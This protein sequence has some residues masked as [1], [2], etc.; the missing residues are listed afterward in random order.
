MN[1]PTPKIAP[2]RTIRALSLCA[3]AVALTP[4]AFG[5]TEV[6][7]G[8]HDV[9]ATTNWSDNAN[10]FN[11]QG[12]GGPG[13]NGNDVIF[14][15]QGSGTQ[16]TINSVVDANLLKPF[17]LTFTNNS[18]NGNFQTVLIPD[19]IVVTNANGLTT[20]IRLSTANSYQT[21]AA[22]VG[23]GTLVQNGSVQVDNTTT[24]GSSG[25]LPWLDLSG[26]TNFFM[27]NN[28]GATLTVAGTSSGSE[29]R[30]SGRLDLAQTNVITVN[31]INI[32]LGTG[33]GGIG[34]TLNLGAGSNV[35]N[36]L[37]F[38][39]AGGKINTAAIKFLGATGGLRIRG[40]NG[41]DSDRNVTLNFGARTSSG[42]GQAKG[43]LDATGGHPVD[44]KAA[45]A[46]LGRSTST[47]Q[48]IGNIGFDT[49]TVDITT[50]NMGVTTSTGGATGSITNGGGFLIVSNMSM[51]NQTGTTIAGTG[52]LYINGTGVVIVSNNIV[53]T[54]TAGVGNIIMTGGSLSV[55]VN[56]GAE[57]NAIDNLTVADSTL[58][59][60]AKLTA[61]AYFTNLTAA[62][63]S[64][65]INVTSV[66]G[67]FAYP[68]QF[69][70]IS[71]VNALGDNS[72][73]F[74]GALPSSFQGY[75]SNNVTAFS[76]D[77]VIT[78]GP[79]LAQLKSIRWSGSPNG[80][81][82]NDV[83]TLNWLTNSISVNYNQGDTVTFDDTLTGT[84]NVN[85]TM[86][87]TP[88]AVTV[89][90]S[91][92]NY[93][94]TGIGTI[95]GPTGLTK[96][97]TGK[98]ILDNSGTND[99]VGA[100]TINAGTLQVGNND[101]NGNL[102]TIGAWDNEG[103]LVFS[104]SNNLVLSQIIPGAG[105]LVQNGNG[106]LTLSVA[107]TYSGSTLVAKGTLALSSSGSIPNTSGILA[108]GGA[109]DV[110]QADPGVFLNVVGA[111]GGTLGIGTN[112]VTIGALGLTNSVITVSPNF[113]NPQT[114][115]A[116]TLAIGGTTNIINVTAVLNVPDGQALPIVIPII[117]YA[118]TPFTGAFNIG[119]TNFP[120]AFVSNDV[121]NSTIDL[122]LTA[123]P[124]LVTWNGGSTTGNNFSD[125]NNWSGVPI[126]LG[127]ALTFDGTTRLTPLNDTPANT[128]YSNITF[129][130]SAGAFTLTG[131][132]LVYTGT[133]INNS[134][135]PQTIL[136][137]LGFT[138]NATINGAV[139][140]VILGGGVTN[141]SGATGSRT[142]TLMGTGILTNLFGSSTVV[143][144]TNGLILNDSAA[145]WT[146]LDN[147]T[148]TRSV[149]PWAFELNSGTFNFG[150]ASSA[151]W[152][153]STSGQGVP[154][155]NQLGNGAIAVLNIS[156][157]VFTTSARLNTGVGNGGSGTINQYGGLINIASQFQG[158]NGSA[159][160]VSAVNLFGGTMNI[161]VSPNA[162]NTSLLTTNLG[163]F[164][165]AS[166]G[167][168]SLTITNSALLNCGI[169]DVS[170]SI[171]GGISGVVNLDGGTIV[172]NSVSTATANQSGTGSTATFN[173]NGGT[174]KARASSAA[175]F[176]GR[177]TA[178]VTPITA[179]VTA[180]GAFIDSDTNTIGFLEPL[181]TD[182][183]LGGAQDG[184]LT[185]LGTGTLRLA[186]TNTYYGDT[187]VNAGTLLAN[188]Q[189]VS[190]TIVASG[191]TLGG[192][193]V[194][195]SNVTVNAGGTLAPG[196]N[197]VGVLTV[198]GNVSLAGATTVEIDK[199]AGTNDLV[200]TTNVTATTITY[201]GTLNV[202]TATGTLAPGDRFQF[203]SATNYLGSF[204]SINSPGVTW[205]TSN[206]N[207]DGSLTVVTV[208]PPGPTTNVTVLSVTLSG[209]NLLVHGT[210]N[211]IPNTSGN[212]VV[213]TST[214]LTTP[215]S[216]WT[217]VQTN[218]YGNTGTV[219]FS[220]PV[221]PGTPQQFIDVKAQ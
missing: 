58:T 196:N 62:G 86:A 169:L 174:L 55:G 46:T 11:V 27:T 135:N 9:S 65:V 215:L 71:Y 218:Q 178:P 101:A 130:G 85:L 64:N 4:C 98:L 21:T 195:G 202:V 35:L 154:S 116:S 201:G 168:S 131:N 157:G 216:Q 100:V 136:L 20:G 3:A 87:L 153:V 194:I 170:R 160:S 70:I 125:S 19:G 163:T 43:S 122:V 68:A 63:T 217:P 84:T 166:R 134:A 22:I 78:N 96:S 171:N 147:A 59:L 107:N 209:S 50:V 167:N 200:L 123:S 203:F 89:N 127:D 48:G 150:S 138:N 186:G 38:N 26:L 212:Y 105:S 176:Q 143:G 207:V 175:F 137:A 44:I 111:I 139:A 118:T 149:A 179:I 60:P 117:R 73:F 13:P 8:A 148:S 205:N 141:V 94:F 177:T 16:G 172:A 91:S 173:F 152:V 88:T 29:A 121:A 106:K 184:G 66:P 49:G 90:N 140:P 1:A 42:S 93:A 10:W 198:G 199:V 129:N 75:I 183:N 192:N 67:F 39:L 208:A 156:N 164:F 115:S 120:N 158:A 155:D 189:G 12:T 220:V 69:P 132:P 190:A 221:V 41:T 103:T 151:P 112:A 182:P 79:A 92:A 109:F 37:T 77:L 95:T 61:S 102:P 126:F 54:T 185:K 47:D 161:G 188:G 187:R 45:T 210:N 197:G 165:V 56:I 25:L 99:F 40:T 17:S 72:T 213:V 7:I 144:G 133:L 74:A 28:A 162:T 113:N 57:G 52:N 32:A 128:V 51:A 24:T 97:G 146:L 30:G 142:L 206:L 18:A 6:W 114:I 181:L 110:S 2:L 33:N 119:E 180:R 204:T 211:N 15:D 31:A 214:N 5:N 145:N 34:G 191:A 36:A 104:R 76:I 108:Q 80:N 14:G 219:D 193:G 159:T 23:G 81:W 53:K 124:Y 83:S 82:T